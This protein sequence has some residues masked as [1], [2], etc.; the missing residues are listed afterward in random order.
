LTS[1]K[2]LS[3]WGLVGNLVIQIIQYI[4]LNKTVMLMKKNYETLPQA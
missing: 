2:I 4:I 1:K 3:I